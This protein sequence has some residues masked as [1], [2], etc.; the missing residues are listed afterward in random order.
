MQGL[1]G[2]IGLDDAVKGR[3]AGREE[4]RSEVEGRSCN[5]IE[6]GVALKALVYCGFRLL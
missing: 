4:D 5:G 2:V 3:V 6:L 1:V